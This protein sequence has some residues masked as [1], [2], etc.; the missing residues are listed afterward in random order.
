[1]GVNAAE[2][3]AWDLWFAASGAREIQKL[4]TARLEE[5]RRYEKIVPIALLSDYAPGSANLAESSATKENLRNVLGA[6][7]GRTVPAQALAF[8]KAGVQL[9]RARPDDVVILYISSHGYVDP[10]GRF[11]AITRET[12]E[13][14]G[15]SEDLLNR[16]LSGR[17]DAS[18]CRAAIDFLSHAVS[19]DELAGWLREIDAG[20]MVLVL[21]SCHSGGAAGMGFRPGPMGDANLGQLA[22][23]KGMLL[24]AATQADDVARGPLEMRQSLLT[25]A[26]LNPQSASRHFDLAAWLEEAEQRV[27]Q[28]Y[29]AH[30]ASFRGTIQKPSFYNFMRVAEKQETANE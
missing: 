23:D 29:A 8:S 20:T 5:T 13:P 27:P 16:C 30:Y 4:L 12:G 2:D 18:R 1:M 25:H 22:Y 7:S 26:L 15:I 3:P 11:F 28:L 24:L 6:L 10:R 19:S 9:A 21:D 17:T 14:A